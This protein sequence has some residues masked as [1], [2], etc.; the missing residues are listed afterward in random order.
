MLSG[1]LLKTSDVT[2]N[3]LFRIIGLC[4]DE[5]DNWMI[6]FGILSNIQT[7]SGHPV[8]R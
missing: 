5:D 7:L 8:S 4:L 6:S 3:V 1:M 2:K